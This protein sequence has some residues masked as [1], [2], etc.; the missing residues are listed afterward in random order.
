MPKDPEEMAGY[1]LRRIT[2][3]NFDRIE[4]HT[5]IEDANRYKALHV[6]AAQLAEQTGSKRYFEYLVTW[7]ES[8]EEIEKMPAR[9]VYGT[10]IRSLLEMQRTKFP[11][12]MHR[13]SSRAR[14][15]RLR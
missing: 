11:D 6:K 5:S 8:S 4:E 3:L 10:F 2:R 12:C 7:A 13:W 15:Q 1:F 9:K 14:L